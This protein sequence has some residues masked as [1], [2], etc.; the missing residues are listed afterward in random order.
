[1]TKLNHSMELEATFPPELALAKGVLV[2][3]RQD[4]RRFAAAEDRVGREIYADAYSWVFSDDLSWPYSFLNV[5]DALA[6]SPDILRTELLIGTETGWYSRVAKK[7]SSVLRSSL[8]IGGNH[9]TA[10]HAS[11]PALAHQH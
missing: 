1:M 4:L 2:Q 9:S 6:L 3:A 8:G 5:C 10:R 7:I 11:R